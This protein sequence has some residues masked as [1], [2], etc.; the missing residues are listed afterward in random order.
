MFSHVNATLNGLSTI[1]STGKEVEGKLVNEFDH[2]QDEHSGA[3]YLTITTGT[4]LAIFIDTITVS[5]IAVITFSSIFFLSS[6]PSIF[7]LCFS[8]M[9]DWF[10]WSRREFWREH[11]PSVI[12]GGH[13]VRHGPIRDEIVYRVHVTNDMRLQGVGVHE[14]AKR[15][16]SDFR[17]AATQKLAKPRA[18]QVG[19]GFHELRCQWAKSVEGIGVHLAYTMNTRHKNVILLDEDYSRRH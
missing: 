3:W 9:F 1:R 12:S 18:H 13:F 10:L 7:F 16:S 11:W 17:D 4:A 15:V 19:G 5:L 8:F 14:S 6:K 2:Y